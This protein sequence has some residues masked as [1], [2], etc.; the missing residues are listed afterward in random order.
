MPTVLWSG[1]YRFFFF[2]GDRDEPAH[3]HVAR[4]R[5]LAKFWIQPVRLQESGGFRGPEL[6]R[7]DRLVREHEADLMEAWHEFFGT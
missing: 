2:S 1:P 3:I 7:I 6:R 5:F 4:D